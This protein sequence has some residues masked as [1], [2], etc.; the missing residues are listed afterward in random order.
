MSQQSYRAY[1]HVVLALKHRASPKLTPQSELLNNALIAFLIAAFDIVKKTT[2]LRD[3]FQK[4]A[5][6][7]VILGMGFE[8]F[9]QI[10]NTFGKNSNLHFR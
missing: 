4:A 8:M 2:T 7:M 5:P 9:R 10:G 3:H 1:R 6:R